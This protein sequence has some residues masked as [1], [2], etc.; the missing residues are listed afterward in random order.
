MQG[1]LAGMER[2]DPAPEYLMAQEKITHET[3]R[4]RLRYDG[5]LRGIIE[6]YKAQGYTIADPEAETLTYRQIKLLRLINDE[7]MVCELISR[8]RPGSYLSDIQKKNGRIGLE[9]IDA[10]AKMTDFEPS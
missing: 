3:L 4:G 5:T 7:S 10:M 1:A 9:M 8:A 6:N 2:A